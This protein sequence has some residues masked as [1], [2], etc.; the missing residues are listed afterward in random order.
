MPLHSVIEKFINQLEF[1]APLNHRNLMLFPITYPENGNPA[2]PYITLDEAFEKQFL[3]ISEVSDGGIVPI[4]KVTNNSDHKILILD[5]EE[6]IGAK[7]NRILNT[8]ILVP[9]KISLPI[10]VSCVEANRW[11]Y[12]SPEFKTAG[13]QAHVNLRAKKAASVYRNL[14][15]FKE[16]RSNQAEVWDI[17]DHILYCLRTESPTSALHDAY[18]HHTVT[19]DDYVKALSFQSGQKGIA[20][21]INNRFVCADIFD[22]SE[23]LEKYWKKL[24]RSYALDAL[25]NLIEPESNNQKNIPQSDSEHL[26][27]EIAQ[28]KVQMLQSESD[29]FKSVGLGDDIRI[30][31]KKLIGTSLVYEQ[32]PIHFAIFRTETTENTSVNDVF[33]FLYH[34]R[35]R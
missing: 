10:P 20:V 28:I 16:Y 4:L 26:K 31:G 34:R 2:I 18:I 17:V 12:V 9:E 19:L 3:T 32:T 27:E 14:K 11:H 24:I 8:T 15:V 21:A 25:V 7:Q 5:G 22:K 13:T 23:T 30:R 29:S 1:S 35:F 6:L 33:G